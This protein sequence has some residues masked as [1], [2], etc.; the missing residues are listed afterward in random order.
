MSVQGS[1]ISSRRETYIFQALIC[2]RYHYKGLKDITTLFHFSQLPYKV[3]GIC[4]LKMWERKHFSAC[5]SICNVVER[6]DLPDPTNSQI[7]HVKAQGLLG[8]L[9]LLN[10]NTPSMSASLNITAPLLR[11]FSLAS[12]ICCCFLPPGL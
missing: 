11:L 9:P 3:D 6:E 8:W 7:P 1:L 12:L 4:F 5:L 10:W 2:S